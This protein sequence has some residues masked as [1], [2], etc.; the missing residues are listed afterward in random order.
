MGPVPRGQPPARGT[1]APLAPAPAPLARVPPPLALG[2]VAGVQAAVA[3]LGLL[4]LPAVLA[5][6]AAHGAASP[7]SSSAVGDPPPWHAP[8]R[9]GAGA[10]VLAHGGSLRIA[11]AGVD[12][13]P[14]GITAAAVA[15]SALAARRARAVL[16]SADSLRWRAATATVAAA[17][18]ASYT[19]VAIGVVALTTTPRVLVAV[20]PSV[21]GAA[22]VCALGTVPV[23]LRG[24]RVPPRSRAPRTGLAGVP[25]TTGLALLV[26]LAAGAVVVVAAVAV[27]REQVLDAHA[28]LTAGA[29]GGGVLVLGQLALVPVAVV[30][31]VA[32][33]AG[34]GVAV[35]V[36]TSI[37]TAGATVGALPALPLLA[38]LPASG[39]LP[40]AA[41]A[42]LL[43]PVLAG[44]AVGV[45]SARAHRGATAVPDTTGARDTTA[46]RRGAQPVLPVAATAVATG[47]VVGVLVA[48][49]SGAV[50]PG[51][52]AQVGGQ[53]VPVALAVTGE[54]A[55]GGA[56][57]L[58]L[59]AAA[60]RAHRARRAIDVQD[61]GE[62]PA[63]AG[64]RE[65]PAGGERRVS[66]RRTPPAGDPA[67][68]PRTRPS[69]V[70]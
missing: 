34:P 63:T 44:V 41:R 57:V 67:A 23:L 60:H 68:A 8:L 22:V 58:A 17:A 39:P 11:G 46:A 25:A 28:A 3:G 61:A 19:A 62:V 9:A 45:A 16:H 14:L 64:T 54:V 20:V 1:P 31:A 36:G 7:A 53:P 40:G 47:V 29:V 65:V 30:W 32:V 37:T 12:V 66:L 18:V 26:I 35:G 4:V 69:P 56:V 6:L 2:A 52:M 55:A 59:R 38:A 48:L 27:H 13:V 70:R 42:L 50:G 15:L 24:P 43:V 21:L 10:W 33:L 49:A 51:R 5:W